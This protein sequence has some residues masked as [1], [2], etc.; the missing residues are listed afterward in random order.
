[1]P[2]FVAQRDLYEVRE[3]PSKI[4]SWKAFIVA[5]VFSEIPWQIFCGILSWSCFYWSVFGVDQSAQRR[6]LILL[7]IIQFYMFASSFAH[8][9]ISAMPDAATG[10]MIA[11]LCFG[12]TLIFNGVMQPPSALPGFWIWMYRVSPLTYYIAGIAATALHGRPVVCSSAEF[13][14]FDPP[15]GQTCGEY[16]ATFLKTAPGQLYN[17]SAISSCQYCALSVADQYLILRDI[18]WADRWRDYGIFWVYFVFNIFGAVCLYYLFR[19]KKWN[20]KRFR[21]RRAKSA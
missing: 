17:P 19:V 6:G 10:G 18:S 7:Y 12:L 1:M 21:F 9:V 14:V 2:R 16:L 11:T 8:L 3:R 15:P 13:S 20:L 5:Q 4:Y